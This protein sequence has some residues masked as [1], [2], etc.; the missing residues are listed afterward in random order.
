MSSVSDPSPDT[1]KHFFDVSS[2][3][4]SGP[5]YTW[6]TRI[7]YILKGAFNLIVPLLIFVRARLGCLYG[8]ILTICIDN[9]Y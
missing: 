6:P 3:V 5:S 4:Y 7:A 8:R 9:M 2:K 1:W